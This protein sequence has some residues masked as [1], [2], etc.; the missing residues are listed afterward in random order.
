MEV[1]IVDIQHAGFVVLL[2]SAGTVELPI[3]ARFHGGGGGYF[4]LWGVNSSRLY[5]VMN[6]F[7]T[8][9]EKKKELI[10][11]SLLLFS[12]HRVC[13]AENKADR[14]K[15]LRRPGFLSSLSLRVKTRAL[16]W[17]WV[18]WENKCGLPWIQW[19]RVSVCASGSWV[20]HNHPLLLLRCWQW[21]DCM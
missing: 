2:H 9:S 5:S 14:R 19:E 4:M 3:G 11:Q 12:A 8:R 20:V 17:K 10:S 21:L 1:C 7:Q 13:S 18:D 16:W 6:P 15:I